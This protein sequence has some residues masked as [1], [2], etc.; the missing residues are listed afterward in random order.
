MKKGKVRV[1]WISVV[2]LIIGCLVGFMSCQNAMTVV[3]NFV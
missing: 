2:M 1:W 3:C